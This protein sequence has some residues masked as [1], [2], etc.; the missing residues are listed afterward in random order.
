MQWSRIKG[1]VL[2][3]VHIVV[4]KQIDSGFSVVWTLI[5]NRNIRH[6]SLQNLWR[7][8][9]AQSSKSATF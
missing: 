4:K 6:H 1:I 5:D 2:F 8:H 3:E 9:E 7:T